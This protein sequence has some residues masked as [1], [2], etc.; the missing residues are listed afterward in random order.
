MA[1]LLGDRARF[2]INSSTARNL[3]LRKCK[4]ASESDGD[5]GEHVHNTESGKAGVIRKPGTNTLE[6]QVYEEQGTPEVDWLA[7]KASGEFFEFTREIVGGRRTQY[8]DCT[9]VNVAADDDD[10]GSH[11]IKVKLLWGDRK[12]L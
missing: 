8:L 11:M 1:N 5:D 10:A 2:Y 12:P 9:V 3:K 4:S 6:L 7:L